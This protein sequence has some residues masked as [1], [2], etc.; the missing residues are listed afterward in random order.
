MPTTRLT[1]IISAAAVAAARRG[2]RIALVRASF[3]GMPRN[4][5]MGSPRMPAMGTTVSGASDETP[6]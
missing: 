4:L 6:R 5:A 2:A 1:P 3:P